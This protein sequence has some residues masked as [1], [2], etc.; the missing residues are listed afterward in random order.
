MPFIDSEANI[1][2]MFQ[3]LLRSND[4]RIKYSTMLLL[5]QNNKPIPDTL[6]TYFAALDGYRFE[7][8]DDLI[9][10]GKKH[11]F[12]HKYSNQ[13]D[14]AK[15][16]LISIKTTDIP[17]S[18]IFIRR[19]EVEIKVRRGYIYFFKYKQRQDDVTWKFATVGLLPQ[20]TTK[21]D[22]SEYADRN[23]WERFLPGRY[24]YNQYDFTE[25]TDTKISE[26]EPIAD[27]LEKQLKKTLYT[28][29][30]S[31]RMF[32]NDFNGRDYNYNTTQS[33]D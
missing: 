31:A 23:R 4:N 9:L 33:G 10:S 6:L 24:H 20:D 14:L 13:L 22:T 18:I 17:D 30:R 28:K 2:Q 19:T 12:P 32:Y 3:Q 29:R 27:Q 1:L 21:F 26:D 11:L 16:K 8:Y 15:S 5:V 25:F 7:L